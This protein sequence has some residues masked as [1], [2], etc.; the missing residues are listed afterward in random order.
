MF[1]Y[2]V[3]VDRNG[4]V[5]WAATVR[6]VS[7]ASAVEAA[8]EVLKGDRDIAS[9]LGHILIVPSNDDERTWSVSAI[10]APAENR[11]VNRPQ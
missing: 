7:P 10:S 4:S 3:T 5:L 8:H 6:A 9:K 11:Q 2:L 1:V